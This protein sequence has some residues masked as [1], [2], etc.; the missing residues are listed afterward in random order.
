M[1]NYINVIMEDGTKYKIEVIDIFNLDEYEEKEYIIYSLG[2]EV[3][4]DQEKIYVSIIENKDDTY[5]LI[6][7][8]DEKEWEKVQEKIA[9]LINEETENE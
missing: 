6:K 1:D 4:D 3:N 2:E 7:I 8:E 5:N 9:N